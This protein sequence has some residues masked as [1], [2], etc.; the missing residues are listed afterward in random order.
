MRPIP[1]RST[2]RSSPAS[3]APDDFKALVGRLGPDFDANVEA[4]LGECV[5]DPPDKLLERWRAELHRAERALAQLGAGPSGAV[6][7]AAAAGGG[8]RGRGDHGARR[9]RPGRRGRGQRPPGPAVASGE[10][11]DG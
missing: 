9:T 7:G 3:S 8:A 2:T 11:A 10:D 5:N 6:A 1:L 4:A